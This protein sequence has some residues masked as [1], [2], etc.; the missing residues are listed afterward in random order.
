MSGPGFYKYRCKYFYTHDC[1]NWV[2]VN[3]SACAKCV[4]LGRDTLEN[5][6]ESL[7][8]GVITAQNISSLADSICTR[9]QAETGIDTAPDIDSSRD[10]VNNHGMHHLLV[11]LVFYTAGNPNYA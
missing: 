7:T 6:Y 1:P 4:S 3:N 9:V 10:S 2:W 11:E 5:G 8:R